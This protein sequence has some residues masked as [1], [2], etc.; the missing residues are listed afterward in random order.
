MA[1]G[2]GLILEPAFGRLTGNSVLQ[3]VYPARGDDGALRFM[4]VA[5]LNL[6]KFADEARRQTLLGVSEVLLIDAQGAVM[7]WSGP[8]DGLPKAGS[9]TVGSA[10]F[11]LARAHADGGTGELIGQDGQAQVWAVAAAP[12]ARAAGLRVM[13]GLPR[14]A[15]VADVR[16]HLKQGLLVLGGAALLLFVGVWS[17]AEWGIR[18]QI[19]RITEMVRELGVGNLGARIAQPYPR[20]ELGGLMAV[21]NG[22]AASLQQQ[23][24]AIDE[25]D[26][27]L[28][29]AHQREITARE[30]NEARLS[31]LAN[32]DSLTE[33][34]NRALFRDRLQ[35]AIARARRSGQPFALMFLDLDRFKNINDSLGHDVGDRLLVAVSRVLAGCLRD[36]DSLGRVGDDESSA[37]VY[38]LG[39]D[40]FTILAE[41]ICG[42]ASAT[43]VAERVLHALSQAFMVGEHELFISASIGITVFND[44]GTDLDGL[45]KQADMAMYRAK[46]LGS[47]TY[48]FF[49]EALDQEA[50]H[51]HQ[52]ETRLRHALERNEFML[53]YQPKA[54]LR[55]GRVTG[56]EALLRWQAP[57]QA[58]V[59][60]DRFIPIL[61]ETG[62]IVAVGAWVLREACAQMM[63]WQR[64]GLR[65]IGLAVNLSARQFRHQDLVGQ[66]DGVLAETGFDPGRLEVE[67]T[68]SMLI[69]DSE[70]VLGIMTRLGAMGVRI[71]ID[72]FGTGHSSL[73]YLKRFNV[74]TLKIDRSFIKDTPEDAEDSAIATAV[75][76]LGH[77]LRLKVV[78]EGV[79]NQ[80]QLDFL[81]AQGCDELQGYLLSPPMDA[82][83]FVVWLARHDSAEIFGPA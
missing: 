75:I 41:G 60:P 62:L 14:E 56:V 3:I 20:G 38:R 5:S 58:M 77:G 72:D 17:L 8:R 55:T 30:Q 9:S 16:L 50:G 63:V 48:S 71:A 18:R 21:L 37:G 27:R 23:R 45:I 32:F 82:N 80:A 49:D 57:G 51:R 46:E 73:K 52:L 76:A 65:P 54:D 22:T 36:T 10:V 24:G 28:R 47:D 13:L 66:I 67:L 1:P 4:L 64:Q 70:S 40:E 74:D 61:E 31:R 43:A 2:A 19:G 39:G 25:L 68:E 29:E 26:Q 34:P 81:R 42:I 53:H 11:E 69:D 79:E 35:Q 7:A 12:A 15:L 44:D 78:A 33:L 6:R 83:A 59:G